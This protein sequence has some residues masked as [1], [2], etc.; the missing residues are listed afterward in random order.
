MKKI[1]IAGFIGGIANFMTA[2]VLQQTSLHTTKVSRFKDEKAVTA[3][4][5]ENA[6]G[7]GFY[8]LPY[9]DTNGLSD[10]EAAKARQA[11][12]E[13]IPKG[14][15]V[16]A[17]IK[18]DGGKPMTESLILQFITCCLCSIALAAL[19]CAMGRKSFSRRLGVTLTLA[20]FGFAAFIVPSWTWFG[21]PGTFILVGLVDAVILWGVTG[22]VIALLFRRFEG[23]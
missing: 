9:P 11:A 1:I 4:L 18:P 20:L 7:P 16:T 15:F 10:E 14:M 23:G 17:A 6:P 19:L 2:G 5:R 13:A 3:V 21:Y 22:S 8:F 12:I